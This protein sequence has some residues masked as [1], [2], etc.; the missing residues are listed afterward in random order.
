[1]IEKTQTDTSPKSAKNF[2]GLG[3]GLGAGIGIAIGAGIGA[4][5]GD[6]TF[7]ISVFLPIGVGGGWAT[8]SILKRKEIWN[9]SRKSYRYF[10]EIW[11][12]YFLILKSTY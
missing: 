11:R 8:F 9:V 3:M 2:I 7:W 12:K 4:V 6:I 10:A 5:T 1:M